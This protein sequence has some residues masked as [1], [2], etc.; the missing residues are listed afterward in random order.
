MRNKEKINIGNVNVNK[1]VNLGKNIVSKNKNVDRTF[2]DESYLKLCNAIR[3]NEFD[4]DSIPDYKEGIELLVSS[5]D[6]LGISIDSKKQEQLVAYY[7]MLVEKN[8]YMNLTGITDFKEVI[9]KHFVDSIALVLVLDNEY[10]SKKLK[11]IDI[12]TGAGFPGIPLKIVFPNLKITLLDSLAKRLK[13]LDEVIDVLGLQNIETLHG[14]CEDLGNNKVYREA[15]D[16][17]VSRAVANLS[18]L[19]EFCIPFVKTGGYFISYKAGNSEEE[20]EEAKFAINKLSGELVEIIENN[21]PDSELSRVFVKIKK[22]NS[23]PKMYPRK[24]GTPLKEPIKK[25]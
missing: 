10:L 22:V 15:Y 7:L 17:V 12:G 3:N 8:K 4:F 2:S 14:R 1:N 6:K 21:L 24:A 11:V 9:V 16:L 18:T 23:T 13:F 19:S 5:L 25:K 20:I